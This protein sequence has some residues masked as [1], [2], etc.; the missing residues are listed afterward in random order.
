VVQAAPEFSDIPYENVVRAV[1][2]CGA[3]FDSVLLT[4]AAADRA[5]GERAAAMRDRDV[6]LDAGTR[7]TGGT[8][9][10]AL[11]G[12][13]L[14]PELAAISAQLRN[15][16]R[17]VYARPDS[18]IPPEKIEVGVKKPG[19]TARGTPAK[20]PGTGQRQHE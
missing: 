11:S 12:L 7:A 13:A 19:L 2:N 8:S 20:T 9:E 6:V 3:L 17:L 4:T 5:G 18:L 1:R 16:Y 14:T 15:Q 10:Q